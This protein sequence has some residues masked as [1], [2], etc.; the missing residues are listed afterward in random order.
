MLLLFSVRVPRWPPVWE[1]AVRVFREHLSVWICAS[2]PF[3]FEVGMWDL[4]V[5]IPDRC[6]SFLSRLRSRSETYVLLFRRRCR[7]RRRRRR[8][9]F[10][11]RSFSRKL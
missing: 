6:F 3:D 5:L 1:K 4:I 8:K 7:R 2:F 11:F 9:L 10:V